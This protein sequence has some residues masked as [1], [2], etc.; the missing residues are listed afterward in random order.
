MNARRVA[1][2]LRQLADALEEE[3]P[4]NDVPKPK[5]RRVP[6]PQIHSISPPSDIDRERARQDLRRLGYRVKP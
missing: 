4:A 1:A 2:L 6:L 5:A 3:E